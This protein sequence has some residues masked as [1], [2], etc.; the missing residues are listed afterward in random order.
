MHQPADAD[1]ADK[2]DLALID[3]N[4]N[5]G[6]AGDQAFDFIG[7]SA[8]SNTAG[9]LRAEVIG[10]NTIVMGDVDGDGVNDL[11]IMLIG[12][13]PLDAADFLL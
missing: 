2:I 7:G 1:G 13:P 6:A 4:I 9:E 12:V 5:P 3:A 10:G 8:F 11:E